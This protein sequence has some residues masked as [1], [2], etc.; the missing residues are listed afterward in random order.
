VSNQ[1]AS[2]FDCS[3]SKWDPQYGPSIDHSLRAN[4]MAIYAQPPVGDVS[5]HSMLRMPPLGRAQVL[6]VPYEINDS[7]VSTGP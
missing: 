5:N 7:G 4:E 1:L 3:Q 2:S 6:A